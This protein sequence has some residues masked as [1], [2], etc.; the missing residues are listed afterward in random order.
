[1]ATPEAI[2]EKYFTTEVARY[3][4]LPL[5]FKS[6]TMNGVPDQVVLSAGV[7][8]FVELKAPNKKPRANQ[9]SVHRQFQKQH[10]P[11]HVLDTKESVDQFIKNT[12]NLT[13]P[14]KTH[15]NKQHTT[16]IKNAF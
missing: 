6:P 14:T 13:A 8:H 10:I 16:I 1:M 7:V 4:A 3:G 15:N 11:V 5:K 9:L 12:L 2:V